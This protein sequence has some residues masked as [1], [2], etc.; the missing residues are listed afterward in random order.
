[1]TMKN[2]IY[3][4]CSDDSCRSQMAEGYAKKYL[5]NWNVQSAGIRAGV[6]DSRA[7]QIMSE[8]K[9]DISS[10]QSKIVDKNFMKKTT[11]VVTLCG[12]AR[13]KCVIPQKAR[14][15]H[16]PIEDP[17]LVTG[18]DTKIM[19]AFRDARDEI[20]QDVIELADQITN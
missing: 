17:A 13:D 19:A 3:F 20:K 6:V 7:V 10:Q 1:M 8:D 2:N 16:W 14:W 5:P 12:E 4:I 11:I 9:I 15:F 18:S